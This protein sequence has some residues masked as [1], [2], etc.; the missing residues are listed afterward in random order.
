MAEQLLLGFHL[1]RCAPELT[2][3]G[4]FQRSFQTVQNESFPAILL[5]KSNL[6]FGH[7]AGGRFDCTEGA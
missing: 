1:Q 2:V 6:V 3:S 7:P 4:L 5:K